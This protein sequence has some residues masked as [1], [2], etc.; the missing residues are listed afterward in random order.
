MRLTKKVKEI[1]EDT[2]DHLS[3]LF[4]TNKD[5]LYNDLL[6]AYKKGGTKEVSKVIKSWS[7]LE[8]ESEM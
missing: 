5:D 2:A 7:Y 3:K 8:L 1:L 6:E 4:N